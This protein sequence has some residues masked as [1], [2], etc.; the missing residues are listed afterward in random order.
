MA[1]D[2]QSAEH[3]PHQSLAEEEPLEEEG[4]MG[5]RINIRV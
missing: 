1:R 3:K 2:H 4:G 5:G